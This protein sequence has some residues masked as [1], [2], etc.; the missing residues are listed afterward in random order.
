[1]AGPAIRCVELAQQLSD[2]FDVTVFSPRYTDLSPQWAK[3]R[4]LTLATGLGK[5]RL[6]EL[7]SANDILFIQANV[8]KPY[9]GLSKLEKYL[10][11]DLYDPYLLSL[12]AQYADDAPSASSSYRLMHLIL[13][14]HMVMADFS[15]CASQRQRDYWLGR[16]CALGRLTPELYRLDPTFA[17][18]IGVV[19]FGLPARQPIR[20]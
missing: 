13:E 7:A 6:Y 16:Y 10:V 17:K 9:P 11:V 3:T 2:E 4:G 5:R 19:P 18:L 14:K 20:T 8:L 12:L 15:A 1:M